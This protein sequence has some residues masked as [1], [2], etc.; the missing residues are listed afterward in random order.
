MPNSFSHLKVDGRVES[1]AIQGKASINIPLA[2]GEIKLVDFLK[3][4]HF[5]FNQ[6]PLW[7]D[8]DE[9]LT[10]FYL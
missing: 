8:L 3:F 1:H 7:L 4:A 5:Y 9:Q 2:N 10:Y 6:K